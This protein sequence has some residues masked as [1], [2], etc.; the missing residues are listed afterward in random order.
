MQPEIRKHSFIFRLKLGI[1]LK[2]QPK[3]VNFLSALRNVFFPI[4]H[5]PV[6]TKLNAVFVTVLIDQGGFPFFV[7][8]VGI[9]RK[10]F[11]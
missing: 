7:G 9:Q 4:T 2:S 8:E 6:H 11:Y 3:N 5:V 10:A 1:D